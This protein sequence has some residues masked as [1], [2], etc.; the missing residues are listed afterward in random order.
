MNFK[1]RFRNG[2]FVASFCAII[3]AA[4]YQI[5]GLFGITPGISQDTAMQIVG[6][7]ITALTGLG[8]IVDPTTKGVKDS[9]RVLARGKMD[10]DGEAAAM[11]AGSEEDT[12][13][14]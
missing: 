9:T 8:V 12:E 1:Y 7:V 5:L 10:Y 3:L 14:V 2:P 4:I 13:E 6:L 11:G